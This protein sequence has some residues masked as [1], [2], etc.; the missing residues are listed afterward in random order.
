VTFAQRLRELRDR[1]GLTQEALAEASGIPVWTVRNYEQGRREPN[2]KGFLQLVVTLGVSVEGF[3]DCTSRDE[4]ESPAAPGRPRS[5]DGDPD[6]VSGTSRST[7]PGN[8]AKP[9]KG[10]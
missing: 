10:N 2:W 6:T 9:R 5:I 1:A 7:R 4:A 3:S 8:R